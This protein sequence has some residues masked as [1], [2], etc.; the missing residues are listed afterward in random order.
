MSLLRKL[1]LSVFFVFAGLSAHAGEERQY[2]DVKDIGIAN[3]SELQAGQLVITESGYEMSFIPAGTFLMGSPATEVGR[4]SEEHQH[5]VKITRP[6]LIARYEVTQRLWKSLMGYNPSQF[7]QCGESCPVEMISWD[8]AVRFCNAMS[9]SEGLD[10]C[11][12]FNNG[13]T[14][15]DK[16]CNGYRLP[17]ESEWEYAARAETKTATYNGDI[18]HEVWTPLDTTLNDICWYGGNSEARFEGGI[19]YSE[20]LGYDVPPRGPQPVGSREPNLWNIYDMIGNAW[21]WTWDFKAEYPKYFAVDPSGP[22]TGTIR[23]W[24]G[25]GWSVRARY[26]RAARRSMNKGEHCYNDLGMRV[27]R[28]LPQSGAQVAYDSKASFA[29]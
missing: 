29:E 8:K 15:W 14:T 5:Y 23:V 25:G 3:H 21:E 7:P 26:C 24:R 17:T 18:E 16:N 9:E 1:T 20:R 22:E 13:K 28:S 6:F 12:T 4:S 2:I 10:K 19:D 27:V 11:Y